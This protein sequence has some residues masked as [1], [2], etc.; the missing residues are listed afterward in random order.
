MQ[1]QS[2]FAGAGLRQRGKENVQKRALI[3]RDCMKSDQPCLLV[4][5]CTMVVE[6]EMAEG[7]SER[8]D[9]GVKMAKTKE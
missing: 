5:E 7:D 4:T 3:S 9:G 6:E 2:D 8:F 1:S